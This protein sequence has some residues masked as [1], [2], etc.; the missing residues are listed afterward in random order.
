MHR[1]TS[2]VAAV[3]LAGCRFGPPT[4]YAKKGCAQAELGTK[5]ADYEATPTRPSSLGLQSQAVASFDATRQCFWC[6]SVRAPN[7]GEPQCSPDA[8]S[9]FELRGDFAGGC[10]PYEVSAQIC[11]VWVADGTIVA[12]QDYCQD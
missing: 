8:G 1:L 4:P 9:V 10:D 7:C 11:T 2:I 3:L 6:P 5:I 12:R